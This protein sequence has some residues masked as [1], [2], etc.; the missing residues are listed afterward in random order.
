MSKP[1]EMR[2]RRFA[3]QLGYRI[4]K[5]RAR[6]IHA[7]NHGEFMLIENVGNFAVMGSNYD[8]TLEG[9]EQFLRLDAQVNGVVLRER[10]KKADA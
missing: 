4:A 6:S 10:G 2:L 1:L 7:T 3:G 9:L 8:A 5:S